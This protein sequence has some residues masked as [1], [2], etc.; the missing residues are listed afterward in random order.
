MGIDPL[1]DLFDLI[2]G[3]DEDDCRGDGRMEESSNSLD[4][5]LDDT[6][7]KERRETS[8]APR[9][10]IPN[11]REV[12]GS[13]K[14]SSSETEEAEP[15]RRELERILVVLSPDEIR[16]FEASRSKSRPS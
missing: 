6:V 8:R 2:L 12:L 3:F 10:T 14:S 5:H 11:E 15:V 1:L 7:R 4:Q 9:R 13:D 16:R